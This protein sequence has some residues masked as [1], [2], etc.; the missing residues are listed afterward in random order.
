M[1]KTNASEEDIPTELFLNIQKK[2]VTHG[3]VKAHWQ[4]ISARLGF[5]SKPNFPGEDQG[6]RSE[7]EK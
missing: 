1:D 3:K 7:E 5:E 6:H 2:T 4:K